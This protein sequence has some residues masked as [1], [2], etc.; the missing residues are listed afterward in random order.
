M[1]ANDMHVLRNPWGWGPDR[2]RAAQINA[3]AEID[4]LRAERDYACSVINS[5]ASE[6]EKL[7]PPCTSDEIWHAVVYMRVKARSVLADLGYQPPEI[8]TPKS[9]DTPE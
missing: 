6:A 9:V 5:L 2:V 7:V 3:A 1:N 4:R 8:N